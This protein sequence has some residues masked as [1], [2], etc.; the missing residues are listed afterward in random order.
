MQSMQ[1]GNFN[2]DIALFIMLNKFK[3]LW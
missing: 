1:F 3:S 2:P